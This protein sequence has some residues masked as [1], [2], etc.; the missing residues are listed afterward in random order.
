MDD[1]DDK[2]LPS[3]DLA[4]DWVKG[5]L[6]DQSRAADALDTKAATFF[7]IATLVLGVGISLTISQTDSLPAPA[8]AFS[9]LAMALY[10]ALVVFAVKA[11]GVRGYDTLDNPE[12][13][14]EFYWAV[15]PTQFKTELLVHMEEAYKRNEMRLVAKVSAVKKLTY[16]AAP[17]ALSIVLSALLAL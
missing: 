13:I 7:S 4:F 14:R 17:Q 6:Y 3:L 12:T 9:V 8:L 15:E 2:P 1:Q 11:L 5:V 16:L 10:L